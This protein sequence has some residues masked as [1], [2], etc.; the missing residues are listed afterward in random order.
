[1]SAAEILASAPPTLGNSDAVELARRYYGFDVIATPL[2][3][4]RDQNFRLQ[5]IDGKQFLLKIAN[6]AEDPEIIRF[7]NAA[8]A[9]IE[10]VAPDPPV[11]HIIPSVD[12]NDMMPFDRDGET[13]WKRTPASGNYCWSRRSGCI[14]K[15]W[16][17]LQ[18]LRW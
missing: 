14:C 4:E 5:S 10:R 18:H 12:G 6:S 11:L 1:M 7:E 8:Q 15:S 3:R 9:H 2:G 17:L 13:Y 16:P